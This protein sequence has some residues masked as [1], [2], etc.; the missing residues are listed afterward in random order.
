V[1]GALQR[2]AQNPRVAQA[3]GVLRPELDACRLLRDEDRGRAA[4]RELE[5]VAGDDAPA[6]RSLLAW[7][8]AVNDAAG[9][10]RARAHGAR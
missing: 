10:E 9:V 2:V 6:W 4:A 5:R 3:P 1:R 8:E 7:Y